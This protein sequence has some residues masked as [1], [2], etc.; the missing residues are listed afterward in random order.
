MALRRTA[1]NRPDLVAWLLAPTPVQADGGT[2]DQPR[3]LSDHDREVL[4]EAGFPVS[5]EDVAH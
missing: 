3:R 5:G 4:G 2:V 1:Q